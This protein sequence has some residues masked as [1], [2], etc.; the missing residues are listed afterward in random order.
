MYVYFDRTG[1][2]KEIVNDDA[3]RQ[4]NYGVNKIYVYVDRD[5]VSE[6]LVSYLLPS[7]LVVGGYEGQSY[8]TVENETIPFDPKRDLY[9]FKYGQPYPFI[10][11]DLEADIN[12]N[13]PLD[14]AGLVHCN[15][16]IVATTSLEVLGGLNFIVEENAVANQKQVAT[17][18]YMSLADYQYLISKTK[19]C[20]PYE[21]ATKN[22][23]LG[24]HTLNIGDSNNG[25]LY[26][27]NQIVRFD[28]TNQQ[29]LLL[30]FPNENGPQTL[31]TRD[32][33]GTQ[34]P[35]NNVCATFN[36]G[37]FQLDAEQGNYYLSNIT[38]SNFISG[39]NMLIIT[40]GNCY[41][42]CPIPLDGGVGRV[43]AAMW[44]A[45]GEA[46][47]IRVRYQLRENNTKLDIA[48][49]SGFTPPNDFN[50]AVQCIKFF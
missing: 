15:M 12:G 40:W 10:V 35:K 25:V 13:S 20:V 24:N 6:I 37:D 19:D 26:S 32:W 7:S 14:E 1:K 29:L 33:V 3:L 36:T 16:T 30:N 47:T 41:A 44:N 2:L 18:E 49:Q 43:V 50:A 23:N 39:S 22:I 48:L 38:V 5:D 42:L 45:N 17:Q 31:A 8:S 9:W 4:G 27:R 34:L 28:G 11:I 46:Q 21:G